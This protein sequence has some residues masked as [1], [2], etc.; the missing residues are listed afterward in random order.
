M[1]TCAVRL[2]QLCADAGVSVDDVR[3]QCRW[4]EVVS[5]RRVM[6]RALY[7][8]GHTIADIARA[9]CRDHGTVTYLIRGR[10]QKGPG[11]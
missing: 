6:C 10:K 5:V 4:P 11:V 7:C 1:A 3:R 9:V 8:E 2:A